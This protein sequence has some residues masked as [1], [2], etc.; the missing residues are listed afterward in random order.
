MAKVTIEELCNLDNEYLGKKLK[1]TY[2]KQKLSKGGNIIARSIEIIIEL[3]ILIG[4][5][6]DGDWIYVILALLALA[7]AI[8]RLFKPHGEDNE[9]LEK[10]ELVKV[11]M[12]KFKKYKS[13]EITLDIEEKK[14]K[15]L[16]NNIIKRLPILL[17]GSVLYKILAF[18]PLLNIRVDEMSIYRQHNEAL[19]ILLSGH[20]RTTGLNI[21]L[22]EK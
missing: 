5:F 4:C 19:S 21:L 10:L 9:Y 1:E 7:Y 20:F 3:V 17:N 14:I 2:Q 15:S 6:S 8:Y 11:A 22:E 12:N 18:I 16:E 13:G